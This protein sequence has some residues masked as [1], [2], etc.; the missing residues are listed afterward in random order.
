M[1][2]AQ[3]HA[4]SAT[5][6]QKA[7][8]A[9]ARSMSYAAQRGAGGASIAPR[10]MD[11]GGL[12]L[13]PGRGSMAAADAAMRRGTL[14]C[15]RVFA[16]LALAVLAAAASAGG[17]S[18]AL[19]RPRAVAQAA[20]T[21][22]RQVDWPSVFANDS[23]GYVQVV[24]DCPAPPVGEATL[25]PCIHAATT[26]ALTPVVSGVQSGDVGDFF[27]YAQLDQI[28]YGDIDGDGLEEA[29][30]P[31]QS[32]GS[33]G[34]FGFLVYHQASP[35]PQLMAAVAGYKL[36]PQIVNGTLLVT[37]PFYFGFEANCCPTGITHTPY[38]VVDGGLQPQASSY[39]ILSP[40]G[41]RQDATPAMLVV[42]GY[43]RA[44]SDQQYQAAY[45]LLGPDMQAAQSY[46]DFAAGF[47][48]TQ[49][50]S[51]VI[52]PG[53]DGSQ[54]NLSIATVD[55]T[56]DGGVIA[57]SYQGTWIVAQA[58]T[59]SEPLYG[60]TPYDLYLAQAQIVQTTP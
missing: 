20:G 19:A 32:Y 35:A 9:S 33:G 11:H 24:P 8:A 60:V 31:T 47:A 55:S 21:P 36:L 44:I 10:G 45:D 57:R 6:G 51:V 39:Q 2:L 13:R 41:T 50:I 28:S 23:S 7:P 18:A 25:Q 26:S 22:L 58:A 38:A 17:V 52:S 43:Y 56:P 1:V 49:S 4:R 14:R 16:L 30:I 29:V 5:A 3:A 15:L 46:A 12:S 27:G 34:S 59:L 48:S 40:D 54:V 53:A 42:A 37:E